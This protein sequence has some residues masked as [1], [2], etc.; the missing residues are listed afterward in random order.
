MFGVK[1]SPYKEIE[2]GIKKAT[3]K[4]MDGLIIIYSWGFFIQ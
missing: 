1:V 4:K 3:H 2:K